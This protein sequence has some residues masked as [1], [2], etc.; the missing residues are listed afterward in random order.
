MNQA[1][2]LLSS[3]SQHHAI[4]LDRPK[5]AQSSKEFEQNIPNFTY[6]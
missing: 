5:E 1:L 4:H 6:L 2:L 3:V